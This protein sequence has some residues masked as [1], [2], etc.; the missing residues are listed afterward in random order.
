[1][2]APYQAADYVPPERIY[3]GKRM[4][5]QNTKEPG[6]T[7]AESLA[8]GGNVFFGK[9]ATCTQ[10]M[11]GIDG[12]VCPIDGA[13][14]PPPPEEEEPPVEEPPAEPPVEEPIDVIIDP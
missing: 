14:P 11:D 7:N 3:K 13:P 5:L 6:M 10:T 1:Y 8:A 4:P 2:F 12:Y 9:I